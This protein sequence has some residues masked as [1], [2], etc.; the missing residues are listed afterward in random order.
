MSSANLKIAIISDL[1][2]HPKRNS[3]DGQDSTYLLT[4]KL[5]S[6]INDHPVESLLK[7]IKDDKLKTDYTFCPGDFT[8]KANI[9]GFISGWSFVGEINRALKA[10]EIIATVGNHDVDPYGMYSN[11]S[12]TTAQGIRNGFP[13]SVDTECDIFWSK[14]C[15]FLER[16]DVRILLINSS[17]F[18]HNRSAATA[19]RVGDTLIDYVRDYMSDKNDNKVKIV[20]SH[21]HPIDHSR[22]NLGEEDKIV[23]AEALLDVLGLH[24]FDLFIHGHKHDPLLRYHP[25]TNHNYKL[26][27][28][29]SG[30]FSSST[31]IQFTSKRNTF[32]LLEMNKD[33][34]KVTGKITTYTFLPTI[35]W[36]INEDDHGFAPYSGFGSDLNVDQ[37]FQKISTSL[38]KK[39]RLEWSNLLS[40][41]PQIQYLIPSEW[42]DLYNKL[43]DNKYLIDNGVWGIPT[44]IFNLNYES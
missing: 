6:P 34:Q 41:V 13:I 20:L 21:H 17:H 5:R 28:L 37:I 44:N 3:S 40:I 16:P 29:S 12:L 43:K 42:Q 32:H 38:V 15:V 36:K 35:G 30:S 26:P 11:Y 25:I 1:H 14:G 18:H 22:Y 23:N 2:C 8:D 10:K 9:Q 24:K 27:I 7:I 4:D 33:G 31:N 39:Q 19:G